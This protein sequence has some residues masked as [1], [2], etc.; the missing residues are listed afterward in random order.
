MREDACAIIRGSDTTR[1]V[2]FSAKKAWTPTRT[3]RAPDADQPAPDAWLCAARFRRRSLFSYLLA[4][5]LSLF[6]AGV[7]PA[8]RVV[9]NFGADQVSYS[10][11]RPQVALS[12]NA[13]LFS[14]AAA[15]PSRFVRINADV[16]EGDI[17]RGR[18]EMLGGVLIAT[19]QGSMRGETASYNTLTAEF[20]LRRAG[21]MVPLTEPDEPP[22]C[23][24][25]YAQEVARAGDV[26]YI[27]RGRF[28]TC[29]RI[30]P[31]YSLQ[32]ERFRWNPETRQVVAYGGSIQL[33]GLKIPV[34]PKIPYTFGEGAN[35]GPD[36]LPFPTY[37]SRDGLRLGWTFN[38][39]NPMD[40]PRT[41]VHLRWRQLRPLQIASLTTQSLGPEV[42][43]RLQLGMR[44]D[45]RRDIDRI[46]PV[47]T[48]PEVGVAGA[49][50]FGGGDYL[51][52]ADLSAGHYTQR[53]EGALPEVSDDRARIQARLTGNADGIYE[54]G[55]VW[56]WLDASQ[57]FYGGG[58]HYGALGVGLG[59]A[60]EL[61]DWLD[62]NAEARQWAT[63]G[64][65]PFVWDDVD[66]KTEIE[67]NVQVNVGD[68]WRVR[69]GAR[70]DLGG[71]ELRA[72]DAEL[73]RRA[74][75]LTWKAGYSD[76][77]DEFSIGAELSG[78]FGNDEP[79][80]DACPPDGPPDYWGERDVDGEAP[81]GTQIDATNEAMDTP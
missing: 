32:A 19:P 2:E 17:S 28:T 76:V 33:Y 47:D 24:F 41:E 31:H 53:R 66:V 58:D 27:N 15:D 51:L 25:A 48:L 65:T 57:A 21:F 9:T 34:F 75:C 68:L 5:A 59:G 36:L 54:P 7:A 71:G 29:S 1:Q 64:A 77:G 46:V 39:G 55:Q 60:V 18:F 73:R 37:S 49:W 3:R 81:R 4:A 45:V 62:L 42:L 52:E 30:D 40:D 14:Q 56:W 72:W 11:D 38:I 50:E 43:A 10:F 69:V 67:S 35:R 79:A 12:G 16:I 6:V 78:L 13:H 26:V 23:G 74:H 44:Q 20:T 63:S 8:E 61:T 80:E 22:V 70:H